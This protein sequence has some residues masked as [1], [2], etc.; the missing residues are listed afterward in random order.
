MG[1]EHLIVV[2]YLLC[3][4]GINFFVQNLLLNVCD[5]HFHNF[6]SMPT[7]WKLLVYNQFFN[8]KHPLSNFLLC[9]KVA[10]F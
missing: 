4:N 1:L 9:I 5:K 6:F 3:I 8:E 10:V 7:G 2:A